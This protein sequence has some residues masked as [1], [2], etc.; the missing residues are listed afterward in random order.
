MFKKA[1]LTLALS[2]ALASLL[3]AQETRH[4]TFHYG[5]TIKNVP[6]GEKVRVWFPMAHSDNFQTVKIVSATGDLSLKKTHES[7]GTN[8]MYYAEASKAKQSDLHFEV[9]YDV[10]RRERLTLGV[11][12]PHLETL[13]TQ[14]Q[15]EKRI[16]GTGRIG[17]DD[18]PPGGTCSESNRRKDVASRQGPGNLRLRFHNHAL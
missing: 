8:E 2:L 18:R 10:V 4:F 9:V 12:S 5:F 17:A 13:E 1:S 3:S 6:Q 15:G 14:R 7:H 16:L 11:Y